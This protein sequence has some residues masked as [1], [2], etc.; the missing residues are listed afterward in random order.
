MRRLL[1]VFAF[2]LAAQIAFAGKF[3]LNDG[4][5]PLEGGQ[6]C[7]FE[8][9]L[10]DDP[11]A[12]LTSFRSV[13]CQSA[14]NVTL[15]PGR[16]NLFARH[17][18]GF[19]SEQLLLVVDGAVEGD[20]R[21]ISMVPA[22]RLAV[23]GTLETGELPGL[24]VEE[25]G[26]VVPLVPGETA[27]GAPDGSTVHPLLLRDGRVE[28][29]GPKATVGRPG[30][31]IS[32]PGAGAGHDVVVGLLPDR[33]AFAKLDT[34]KREA[35]RVV[36]SIDGEAPVA[37]V[38]STAA[39]F[40]STDSLALF[41]NVAAADGGLKARVV[42]DDWLESEVALADFRAAAP[43]RIAPV[44][45][46]TVSWEV[47]DDVVAIR[48]ELSS[49]KCPGAEGESSEAAAA[50][51]PSGLALTLLS[52]PGMKVDG[53]P[54]F[55]DRRRCTRTGS[56][57]LDVGARFGKATF[58]GV[59]PGTHLLDL[60]FEDLPGA[61]K[62]IDVSADNAS[63]GIFLQFDR[64]FGKVTRAGEPLH[65][66]IGFGHGGISDPQTGEYLAIRI[67]PQTPPAPPPGD[68]KQRSPTV[69][70]EGCDEEKE[71]VYIPDEPP[72]PNTRFDIE[73][74][75]NEVVI[76]AV[77][78]ADGKPLPNATISMGAL[79]PGEDRGAHFAGEMGKTDELGEYKLVDVPTNRL[80]SI[81][82]VRDDYDRRCVEKLDLSQDPTR[83]FT[84]ALVKSNLRKGRIEATGLEMAQVV[85]HTTDGRIAEIVRPNPAGEFSFKNPHTPGEI[86]SVI[87]RNQPLYVFRF[88]SLRDDEELVIRY[89]AAARRS[90]HV[91]LPPRLKERVGFLGLVIGDIV[92][93]GNVLGWHLGRRGLQSSFSASSTLAVAD[94]LATGQLS[95][96]L[97]PISWLKPNWTDETVDVFYIPAAFSL[98]RTPVGDATRVELGD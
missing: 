36:L 7:L 44:T 74:E 26:M 8:A 73:V 70:L 46:L 90:F 79:L 30:A 16:W 29:I 22:N 25:S 50:R 92:V 51:A 20:A 61:A 88:P 32:I 69:F 67:V 78:A 12:R 59:A 6:V 62:P 52:C 49:R 19:V 81:C 77:D 38:N 34:S 56:L 1:L 48:D 27:I 3:V 2:V 89:P 40:H 87:A 4:D 58:K 68:S 42:G 43:L 82:A 54:R 14:E 65:V 84:L 57:P 37:S 94:V 35:G 11:V 31:K 64:Y 10:P 80:L 18:D 97:A 24:Y 55:Y 33:D 72:V 9:G 28:R 60:V 47:R 76:K 91:A 83:K 63:A 86:V 95:V 15:R 98:P 93:P 21:T 71:W 45:T 17:D 5:K 41:R 23:S 75:A 66:S 13:T 39:A 85:W 53:Q 96:M